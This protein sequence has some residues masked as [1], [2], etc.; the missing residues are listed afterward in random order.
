MK[1]RREALRT[2]FSA[3]DIKTFIALLDRFDAFL[4]APVEDILTEDLIE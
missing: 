1:K 4:R 3:E 2:E